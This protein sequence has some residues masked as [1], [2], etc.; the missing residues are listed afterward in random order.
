MNI[1]KEAVSFSTEKEI[2]QSLI[3]GNIFINKYEWNIEK[4]RQNPRIDSEFLWEF[5]KEVSLIQRVIN[6][7]FEVF[8]IKIKHIFVESKE[9]Y[10]KGIHHSWLVEYFFNDYVVFKKDGLKPSHY[11]KNNVNTS[12]NK[13]RKKNHEYREFKMIYKDK[14]KKDNYINKKLVKKIANRT[15]RRDSK[16]A[17]FYEKDLFMNKYEACDIW[18]YD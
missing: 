17:I 11:V 13:K 10:R 3:Y 15:M 4:I 14:G 6:Y 1:F 8:I 2:Y 16:K 7:P 9:F 5:Y 18:S 12:K